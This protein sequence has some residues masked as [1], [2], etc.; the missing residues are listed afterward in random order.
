MADP[1]VRKQHTSAE[2]DGT[3]K[4]GSAINTHLIKLS[5]LYSQFAC[6]ISILDVHKA[7]QRIYHTLFCVYAAHKALSY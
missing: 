1:G 2:S 7:L 6:T 3:Q 4:R 5:I